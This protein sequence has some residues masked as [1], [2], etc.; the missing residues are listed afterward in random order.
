MTK[1]IAAAIVLLIVAA[2]CDRL[3]RKFIIVA[4]TPKVTE[5]EWT[6]VTV[7]I[8]NPE[9]VPIVPLTLTLY[10]RPD[11]TEYFS[12]RRVLGQANFYQPLQA[13]E[14]HHLPTLNRIEA[15][16][17]RDR[18]KWRRVPDSRFL[19]PRILLPGKTLSETF[20][21]QAFAAYRH[22][23]YCELVYLS[24][25][26]ER[27]RGH[28]FRRKTLKAPSL[29]T[30]RYTETFERVDENRLGDPDPQPHDYLLFRPRGYVAE[31]PLT[32]DRRV[33][34]NVQPRPF[35]YR[36]AAER[37]RFGASAVCFFSAQSM[38]AFEY[39]DDG[40]WFVGPDLTLKLRG[41]YAT[42]IANLER[43]KAA[44]LELPPPPAQAA[45]LRDYLTKAGYLKAAPKPRAPVVAIP[46]DNLLTVL[47]KI[48][49]LGWT[50]AG[51]RWAPLSP[52]PG[53]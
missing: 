24:F 49:A 50:I 39:P 35:S 42:L 28:L 36:R 15:I 25:D 43:R 26:S 14:V 16:H 18:G 1:R 19:H 9:T 53:S 52:Q 17:V 31:L 46:L 22:L 7:T 23:L 2:G 20:T 47:E 32:L 29:E 48:E 45:P 3:A 21:F 44:S 8:R 30:E 12:A 33:P 4:S 38:W 51:G 6:T 27:V 41:Q 5:G 34:L 10:A 13:T 11:P 37:A 40:T